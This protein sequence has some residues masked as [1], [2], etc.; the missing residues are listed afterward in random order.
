MLLFSSCAI[1]FSIFFPKHKNTLWQA[2]LNTG[3]PLNVYALLERKK[4]QHYFK[5]LQ[6]YNIKGPY[7]Q[8]IMCDSAHKKVY[9]FVKVQMDWESPLVLNHAPLG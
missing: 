7:F 6:G 3:I 8:N 1:F 5:L 4:Q 9:E 2:F